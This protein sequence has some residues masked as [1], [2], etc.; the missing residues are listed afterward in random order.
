MEVTQK[1]SLGG[2]FF[3]KNVLISTLFLIIFAGAYRCQ[4]QVW[5]TNSPMFTPRWGQ[6][7]TELTNGTLLIA[8]G[9]VYNYGS[10]SFS[11]ETNEAE[12]FN[13]HTGTSA[14][15]GFMYD[16]R[17][18]DQAVR[19][20]NGQVL[21]MG[22]G[23]DSSS[24]I[25]DPG[26]AS[27]PDNDFQY[28]NEERQNFISVL[29]T[30]G[31]VLAAGGWDDNNLVDASSAEVYDPGSQ[32]WNSVQDM[33]YAADTFAAVLLTNGTVLVCGGESN[34]TLF[35]NAAIYNPGSQTWSSIASMNEPRSGHA[36]VLLS[37]GQ[38]L[39]IGGAGDNTTEIYDPGSGTWSYGAYMNDYR[40]DVN[41]V[42]LINQQIL[43]SGDGNTDVEIY[44]PVQQMWSYAGSLPYAGL[45]QTETVESN[46]QV[47]V[48]GGDT[49]EYNGPGL[50][51]IE[52]FGLTNAPNLI[53]SDSNTTGLAPLTVYFTSPPTDDQGNTVTN[54]SWNFGDGYFS[55]AQ[56]PVHTYAYS[57]TFTPIL[58]AYSTYSSTPLNVEGLNTV[59]VTNLLVDCTNSPISG[60]VP[61]TVQFTSANRDSAGNTVTSWDWYF[62]DGTTSNSQNPTHTYTTIGVFYPY[63]IAYS[64]YSSSQY[65]E[66]QA[67]FAVTVTNVPNPS[68]NPVYD[69]PSDSGSPSYTNGTGANVNGPLTIIGQTLY[70][71]TQRG[72][73]GGGGTI[74]GVNTSGA[75]F[76][77][78]YNF[79]SAK[80]YI[81]GDGLTLSGNTFYG[82]TSLGGSAG[83]GGTVFAVST[84]GTG[85]TNL[86]NFSL[87]GSSF[88]SEPFAG[89]VVSGNALFGAT[90]YGGQFASGAIFTVATNG[91]GISDILSF[92][93]TG[94]N[95]NS[96]GLFPY[97][98]LLLSGPVLYG[99]TENGGAYAAGTVFSLTT[100]FPYAYAALHYFPPLSGPNN[101]N[102]D[103]AYPYSTVVLSG[104]NLYGTTLYGG[105]YGY[106][107]IFAVGTNG[108]GAW[109]TNLYSFTGA[110]DGANPY[111]G[112]TLSGNTLYGTTQFGGYGNGNIF[113]INV[114]GTGFTN[115]YS[116]V[117]GSNGINPYGNMIL[118]G[119]TLYG[120]AGGGSGGGVIFS[121]TLPASAP[122]LH[123]ALSGTNA[124]LTWPSSFTGYT[125]QAT[126]K[127]NPPIM[128]T[129]VLPLPFNVN[130]FNTVTNP[131]A[132][133]ASFYRLSQ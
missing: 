77:N 27:W 28:M 42:T 106:G 54:W 70:G 89:L 71:T 38:V 92:S 40:T 6:T 51:V 14:L 35:D 16:T 81:P 80:G 62:G 110:S 114:N 19:L 98:N 116:F 124:I 108:Y 109:F 29:L 73:T 120:V 55:S 78:L 53:V 132:G 8:G 127:L 102:S 20:T 88:G 24:E 18:F 61:L 37:N 39:V 126:P 4:A 83:G 1:I 129:N 32:T 21:V 130:G 52:S 15:T 87:G 131:R 66:G 11:E 99:T 45:Q 47:V 97:E 64:T 101:T 122:D 26:S 36:A 93:S 63:L 84:N 10:V 65:V 41:A 107:G 46:R 121:Y 75:G 2:R 96:D 103:G 13:P 3:S 104:T 60:L 79:T 17:V 12:I 5:V 117:G 50:N 31:Q 23:A 82:T 94:N 118:S 59:N 33:P 7:A 58:T 95:V 86:Y 133:T 44:D 85:Y 112:L 48:T 22:G 119:N 43:I 74:F 72:G 56:S 30:N 125:L 34:G 115:L 90:I 67:L 113:A 9:Q 100:N 57:G 128:W 123:I 111:G 25:Y 49:S 105:A 68:F 76:T 91:S 69:F